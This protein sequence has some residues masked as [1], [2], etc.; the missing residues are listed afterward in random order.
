MNEYKTTVTPLLTHWGYCIIALRLLYDGQGISSVA[1]KQDE[2]IAIKWKC[3][4][5]G[6]FLALSSNTGL[7]NKFDLSDFFT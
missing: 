5:F 6:I 4:Q 7:I 2:G 1:N 3:C